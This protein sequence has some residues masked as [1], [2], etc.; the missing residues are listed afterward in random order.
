MVLGHNVQI[1]GK[2]SGFIT[3]DSISRD[4][5]LAFLDS[6]AENCE[7]DIRVNS[8]VTQSIYRNMVARLSLS[9]QIHCIVR[10]DRVFLIRKGV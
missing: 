7:V 8:H 5:I 2:K 9:D 3:K 1:P 4:D 6:G 10:H